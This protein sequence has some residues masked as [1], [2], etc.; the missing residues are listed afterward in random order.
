MGVWGRLA[1]VLFGLLNRYD[2]VAVFGLVLIEEAGVPLPLPGDLVMVV[3]GFR[4]A[5]GEMNPFTTLLLLELATLIGSSFLFWLAARGGRPLLYRY[6]RYIHL[7]RDKLDKAERWVIKH[8]A[9][10][11]VVGRIVPGLRMPT[12]IAAGVFGI[13]YAVFLPAVALGSSLYILFF[14]LLGYFAGPQ[15]LA[16]IH[17]VRLSLRAALSIVLFLALGTFMIVMYRRSARVRHLPREPEPRARRLETS[18]MAGFV[19]TLEMGLGTNGLLYV[20][21]ALG[22][23]EAE[24]PL[25]RLATRGAA[26]FFDG[27]L[28]KFTVA[29]TAFLF[30]GGIGWAILY[31]HLADRILPG[32]SWVR[33]LIFS[34]IPM[35]ASMLIV[36]PLLGGGVFGLSLRDS[37]YPAAGEALRNVLFGLGLATSY[38]LLRIARQRPIRAVESGDSSAVSP[39]DHLSGTDFAAQPTARSEA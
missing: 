36:L 26:R 31:G 11:V 2:D 24:P 38:T 10:A 19:A 6:G 18:V 17:D 4:A 29:L 5:Q 21:S 30:V 14:F 33:G 23:H 25:I 20:L 35:L 32:P 28:F 16:L 13:R 3:A 8:G 9:L 15:A 37:W 12:A 34:V 7:E 39:A 22:F 27:D 1:G